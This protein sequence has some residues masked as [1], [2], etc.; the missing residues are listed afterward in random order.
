[1]GGH[2]MV[3]RQ[4]GG[5]VV[6]QQNGQMDSW[7]DGYTGTC[8]GQWVVNALFEHVRP[9]CTTQS[10]IHI[11]IMEICFDLNFGLEKFTGR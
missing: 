9:L 1:M 4:M 11:W 7:E 6:G 5:L 10:W 3:A 2:W 8:V